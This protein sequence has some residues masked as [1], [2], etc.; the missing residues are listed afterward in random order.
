MNVIHCLNNAELECILL[1]SLEDKA[2]DNST[3]E[4]LYNGAAQWQY[5]LL[6]LTWSF[7]IILERRRGSVSVVQNMV[8][9]LYSMPDEIS[10]N[11]Q[12]CDEKFV[13][14]MLQHEHPDELN[15]ETS[16]LRVARGF[17]EYDYDQDTLR[18]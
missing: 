18:D 12:E 5:D 3:L 10:L 14:Y 4:T 6:C 16:L 1:H 7:A 11:I 2:I 17:S 8:P 13:K 15:L 9:K